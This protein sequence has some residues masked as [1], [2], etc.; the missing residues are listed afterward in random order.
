MTQEDKREKDRAYHT[1]WQRRNRDKRREYDARYR[2]KKRAQRKLAVISTQCDTGA[3][4]DT[5]E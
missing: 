4:G 5:G 2:L 1:E 3:G